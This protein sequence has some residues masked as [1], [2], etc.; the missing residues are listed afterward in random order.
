MH[1]NKNILFGFVEING[2]IHVMQ[3]ISFFISCRI[4]V[5]KV[6]NVIRFIVHIGQN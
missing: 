1:T 5:R 3:L 6:L 2:T 4:A